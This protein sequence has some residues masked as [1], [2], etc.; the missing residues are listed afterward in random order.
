MTILGIET[1]TDVCSAALLADEADIM[2]E[3]V[4]RKS[5]HAEILVPMVDRLLRR[6]GIS[7]AEIDEIIHDY[8]NIGVRRMVALRG[9][10]AGSALVCHCA[11]HG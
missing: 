5:V 10:P 6:R 9:D 1:A 3:W 11:W 8:W 4:E 7:A 2:E